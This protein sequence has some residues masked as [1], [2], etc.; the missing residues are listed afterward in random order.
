MEIS[1]VMWRPWG[2]RVFLNDEL[3]M[4]RLNLNYSS[5]W[6]TDCWA[7]AFWRTQFWFYLDFFASSSMEEKHLCKNISLWIIQRNRLHSGNTQLLLTC[8]FF[9][10]SQMSR[11]GRVHTSTTSSTVWYD[12][13][14]WILN[15]PWMNFNLRSSDLWSTVSTVT[16]TFV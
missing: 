11:V 6:W 5:G 2:R 1:G 4:W 16:F 12:I 10:A 3:K 9:S 14:V 8:D 13:S 15:H 7:A